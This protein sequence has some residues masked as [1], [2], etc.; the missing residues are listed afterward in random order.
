VD[1]S[2]RVKVS[3]D[4]GTPFMAAETAEIAAPARFV[5]QP[6]LYQMQFPTTAV[7]AE[8]LERAKALLSHHSPK[9]SLGDVHLQAMRLLVEAL[10]KQ[11]YGSKEEPNTAPGRSRTDGREEPTKSSRA[12]DEGNEPRR[13]GRYVPAKLRRAVFER[14]ERQCAYLERQ[15]AYLDERGVRCRETERL[16]LH[17]LEPFARGGAHR[18]ENLSLRC[19]AHNTLAAEQDFGR[20]HIARQRDGCRLASLRR[21][22]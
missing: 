3:N 21:A 8:L 2:E 13:R 19:Q 17:H 5:E 20:E 18:L 6:P 4:G 7:H 14:D 22:L 11:R 12:R 1:E 16:E 10:E 15:C 9:I